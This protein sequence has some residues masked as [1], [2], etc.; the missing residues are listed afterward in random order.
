MN[1]SEHNFHW[2][3]L[4]TDHTMKEVEDM[5]M[6]ASTCEVIFWKLLFK[7]AM[8]KEVS[9]PLNFIT[10]SFQLAKILTLKHQQNNL[11][12]KEK[13]QNISSH[14]AFQQACTHHIIRTCSLHQF[15]IWWPS[16]AEIEVP[17][18]GEAPEKTT[19]A[20]FFLWAALPKLFAELS[21]LFVLCL[22]SRSVRGTEEAQW[23]APQQVML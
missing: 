17:F 12:T 1:F 16:V 14:S 5:S 19:V 2:A 21:N 22:W 15:T 3:L 4:N 20:A 6:D 11:K 10:W 7:S 18:L 8:S 9:H 13:Y 23:E